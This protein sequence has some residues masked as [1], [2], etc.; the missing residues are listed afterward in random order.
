MK[1]KKAPEY[2]VLKPETS[3]DSA[4]LKSKGARWP[5]AKTQIIHTGAIKI[6][7]SED[8]HPKL[9]SLKE[10]TKNKKR[11]IIVLNTDS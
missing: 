6:N 8:K 7:P 3:S 10:A 2:S 11:T 4:S 9:L 5:S 1:A